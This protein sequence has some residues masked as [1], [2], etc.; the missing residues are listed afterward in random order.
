[1]MG[2][3]GVCAADVPVCPASSLPLQIPIGSRR[4]RRLNAVTVTVHARPDGM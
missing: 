1:M 4:I 3:M 2:Q